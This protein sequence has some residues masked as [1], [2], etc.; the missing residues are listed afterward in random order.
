[1]VA[2]LLLVELLLV[3]KLGLSMYYTCI[4]MKTWLDYENHGVV[5]SVCSNRSVEWSQF[6][7]TFRT[8]PVYTVQ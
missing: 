3:F 8:G 7:W 5:F 6:V 2:L 1:M 4:S